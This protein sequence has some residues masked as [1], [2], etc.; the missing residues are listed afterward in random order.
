MIDKSHIKYYKKIKDI[1][2]VDIT[3]FKL[4]EIYDQRNKFYLKLG[5]TKSD[6]NNKSVLELCPGTG[7]NAFY[8]LKQCSVKKIKLVDYNLF[9]IKKLK[10][11]LSNFNNVKIVNRD[12]EKFNT[13][14]KFDY[15]IIEN[16]LDNL[17]IRLANLTFKK[18]IKFTKKDGKIILTITN[19]YASLSN[20]LRYLYSALLIKDNSLSS[21]QDRKKFL[22]KIFSTHLKYLSKKTRTSE[23]WVLDNILNETYMSKTEFFDYSDFKSKLKNIVILKNSPSF[24]TDYTWYKNMNIKK[25]NDY[26]IKKYD[27]EYLN[28]LDFETRFSKYN[29]KLKSSLKNIMKLITDI[30]FDKEI[31][32]KKLIKIKSELIFIST[33]LNKLSYNN[34]VSNALQELSKI[35]ND[36]ILKKPVKKKTTYLS[37]LW[38]TYSINVVLAKI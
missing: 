2:T 14:E 4:K 34:K 3:D 31:N 33:E 15:V 37:K 28:Y 13:E 35:V 12:V 11:N 18:I 5:I 20:K 30:D 7:Y 16:A 19:K 38:S 8:L 10:K 24:H 25:D 26:I 27:E 22:S 36:F 17:S 21:F 23:K 9:S 29:I 6:F 32:L 1:P